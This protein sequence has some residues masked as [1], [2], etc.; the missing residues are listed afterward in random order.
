MAFLDFVKNR[1]ASAQPSV[2]Q[3]PQQ[4]AP[5]TEPSRSVESLSANAKAQ[6]VEA[7]RPAAQ[8]MD[9]ATKPSS[10]PV[11]PQATPNAMTRGRSLGMER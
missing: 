4:S 11:Q 5:A 7:A 2:A 9:R 1:N 6:A 10:A 3:A 8:L